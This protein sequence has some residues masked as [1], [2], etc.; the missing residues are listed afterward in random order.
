MIFSQGGGGL[1][2]CLRQDTTPERVWKWHFQQLFFYYSKFVKAFFSNNVFW[3]LSLSRILFNCHRRVGKASAF[4]LK[5]HR[6]P[7]LTLPLGE[8]AKRKAA[9]T[10]AEGASHDAVSDSHRKA[11]FT[12]AEVLITLGIIG[13]VAA[14]T[15]PA[16]TANYRKQAFINGL[17]KN[18]SILSQAFKMSEL[19]NG[20]LSTWNFDQNGT[21]IFN[22][23]WRKYLKGV[24][25]CTTLG[26]GYAQT[27]ISGEYVYSNLKGESVMIGIY[28]SSSR[29]GVFLADGTFLFFVFR[30]ETSSPE[31]VRYIFIDVNGIKLPNTFGKD[32]FIFSQTEKGLLPYG[33]E[34]TDSKLKKNCYTEDGKGC[35]ALIYKNGWEIP[36]DYPAKF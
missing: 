34:M 15:L 7:S 30:T 8:G 14:M 24:T 36:S 3:G 9:F 33:M 21:Q 35:T 17:K 32:V 18:Y 4:P 12:L 19:E 13:V 11:A 28:L 27:G 16:I 26:C 20:E 6:T 23:Y 25:D 10:L 29:H 31:S 1:Y 5:K 2:N 22:K